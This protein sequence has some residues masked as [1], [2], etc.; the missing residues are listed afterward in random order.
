[1]TH[2]NPSALSWGTPIPAIRGQNI[3]PPL[4]SVMALVASERPQ[5]GWNQLE[6]FLWEAGVNSLE[7]ILLADPT[8]LALIGNMGKQHATVLCNYAKCVVLPVLGL[9]GT[10]Q[11]D[12][13]VDEDPSTC[14]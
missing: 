13:S 12:E 10:Y 2:A 14:K 11:E 7:H 4:S 6:E 9:Q 3:F 1:M 5:Y 8:V